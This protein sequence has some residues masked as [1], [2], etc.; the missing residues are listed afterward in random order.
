M[1]HC[2]RPVYE[3]S[4]HLTNGV[5]LKKTLKISQKDAVFILMQCAV[6]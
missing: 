5:S 1:Y 4:N 3:P 2:I 6:Y